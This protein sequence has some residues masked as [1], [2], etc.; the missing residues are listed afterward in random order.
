MS[1]DRAGLAL[2]A[3][4]MLAGGIVLGLLA[5]GGQRDPLTLTSGWMIGTLFSGIALTAV[6]GPLWLVMHVAGL[7]K[8]HHAALVGAVTAMAIFV[9]AQTY[10]FGIFQ[11]PPMDNG[12]WIYRWLSA[13]A[14]S[15]VL[16]LIAALIGL[17]MWRVAYRRQ[18]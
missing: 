15:A 5:L 14:S 7:R 18:T 11:M 10:G 6:G 8:P 1:I 2:A 17:V 4:S 13:L 3:G 16:A 12:A 9:G